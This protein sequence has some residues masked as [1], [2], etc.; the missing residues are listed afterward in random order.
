MFVLTAVCV[1]EACAEEFSIEVEALEEL[2]QALCD[3][4][5]NL[6]LLSVAE[7]DLAGAL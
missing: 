7:L 6:M 2:D 1:D 4:D 5:C 3:C